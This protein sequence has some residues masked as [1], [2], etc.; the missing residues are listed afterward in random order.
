M[1]IDGDCASILVNFQI[2]DQHEVLI[3]L[4]LP[5]TW[6]IC[7]WPHPPLGEGS[8]PSRGSALSPELHTQD[9][10]D[11]LGQAALPQFPQ[12]PQ[13]RP[14]WELRR[15][16]GLLVW[17]QPAARGSWSALPTEAQSASL[18][19][20]TVRHPHPG[21][22]AAGRPAWGEACLE[23][24]RRKTSQD[25]CCSDFPGI[26]PLG[27]PGIPCVPPRSAW[28]LCWGHLGVGHRPFA[29]VVGGVAGE[30]QRVFP[31]SAVCI[32]LSNRSVSCGV[33]SENCRGGSSSCALGTADQSAT[34]ALTRTGSA[35][36]SSPGKAEGGA[37]E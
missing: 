27:V 15:S 16:A 10:G 2:L 32:Y 25:A 33:N 12:G 21:S 31:S 23:G 13:L 35:I 18:G 4:L 11:L 34:R 30:G 17:P 1:G 9:S 28:G 3:S 8:S 5:W 6:A 7:A 36:H 26:Q 29:E 37:A 24:G 19:M 20:P 22:T 14:H